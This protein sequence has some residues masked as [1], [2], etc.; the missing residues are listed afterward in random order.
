MLKR[1]HIFFAV[2][3][4]IILLPLWMWPAW[5]LTPKKKTVTAIVDKTVV[6][7]EGQEHASLTWVLN[8]E[9]FTKTRSK[10]Y[11]VSNDYFGFFPLKK[12]QFRLKGLERF[13]A[14]QIDQLSR[15]CDLAYFTDTYGIYTNEWFAGKNAT[16]RS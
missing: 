8:H 2:T 13:S 10:G 3:P 16:E 12:D 9:R 1:R 14:E 15:D 11:D 5:L 6:S 7:K 4:V